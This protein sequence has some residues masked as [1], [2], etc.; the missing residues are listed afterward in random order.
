MI[1]NIQ[2]SSYLDLPTNFYAAVNPK[3]VIAPKLIK[4]NHPLATALNLHDVTLD[5]K[6]IALYA[7]NWVPPQLQSIALAYAGHQFGHYVPLL[8]DGRAVLLGELVDKAGKQ[9]DL[10]LKGS[11]MT[12]FSRQGDGRAPLSA[13]LREYLVSEAMHGLGIAT[14]RCLAAV[15]SEETIYRAE[16]WVPI[17]VL[18]R[19]AASHVRV[20][21]FQYAAL[22]GQ[23]LL[24]SLAD[25]AIK[26]HYPDL[27][28]EKR[29]YVE[30]FK[31]VIERQVQLVV[32][33]LGVGFI[34]GVMNTD[35]MAISG[36]TIDYGPCAFMDEFDVNMVFSSI[37]MHGRYAFGNQPNIA[38]W[39]M[40]Q[41]GHALLPLFPNGELMHEAL[42]TFDSRFDY[43]WNRKL[44][45]KL[46]LAEGNEKTAL[47]IDGFFQL[48]QK[49]KP[50]YTNTFRL[51]CDAVDSDKSV[52]QLL[53]TFSNDD[54]SKQWVTAWLACVRRLDSNKT[55]T[56][57]EAVNPV[58][59]PRNHLISKAINAFVQDQNASLMDKL[60]HVFPNP[61]TQQKNTEALQ[62]LPSPNERVVQTFC[63]T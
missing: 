22:N 48:M 5:D 28:S 31:Q 42:A 16:G 44:R 26:R 46:G 10:Q 60:L 50:D 23:N 19:I 9:W 43:Y 55:K 4:F 54:H 45:A 34:H 21:S 58:Y 24:Q 2:R 33:W 12:P 30:F 56:E 15:S 49:H 38:K 63:G 59:I 6:V 62:Q 51:L 41:L 27:L 14:T 39:N 7:G 18:T 47:L 32:D 17:G 53:Q 1:A 29:P 57:M 25:Y 37:D 61:F 8:G 36:E 20:G 52:N 40:T 3:P 11:G 35:N 13:V